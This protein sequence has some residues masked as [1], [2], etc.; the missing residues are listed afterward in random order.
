[1]TTPHRTRCMGSVCATGR[2]PW[3]IRAT[4]NDARNGP[5]KAAARMANA[6][7]L[8]VCQRRDSASTAWVAAD[9]PVA[10]VRSWPTPTSSPVGSG[11]VSERVLLAPLRG[12]SS[13]RGALGGEDAAEVDQLAGAAAQGQLQLLR[14]QEVPVERVVPVDPHT[15]VEVG[16]GVDDPLTA[17]RRPV[18]G[19]RDL[20]GGGVASGEPPGG[21]EHREADRVAVDVGISRPL[22]HGLERGDGPPELLAARGVL[23]GDSHRLG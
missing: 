12:I 21:L 11:G 18:L 23:A 2:M 7:P 15:T 19:D 4:R 14:E 9:P 22:T 17:R 1:M 6:A 8:R 16:C 20:P 10:L 3:S 5:R 13:G